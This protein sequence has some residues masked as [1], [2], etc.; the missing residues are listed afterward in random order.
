MFY[1]IR[2]STKISTIQEAL[3]EVSLD[4]LKWT[5]LI[6]DFNKALKVES[7]PKKKL[8]ICLEN[9][10]EYHNKCNNNDAEVALSD[11]NLISG[12]INYAVLDSGTPK[13]IAP[14]KISFLSLQSSQETLQS[15]N[16][17][18]IEVSGEGRM[19][20]QTPFRSINIDNTLLIPSETSTLVAM[21]PFLNNGARLKVYKG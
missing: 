1:S 11:R 5:E 12:K 8:C 15:S 18:N 10:E 4:I 14:L 16:G 19:I 17:N 13:P 21:G 20:L 3:R 6:E 7:K 2:F 9:C